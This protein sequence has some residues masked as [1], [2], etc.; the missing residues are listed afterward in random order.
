MLE[1]GFSTEEFEAAKAE[2]AGTIEEAVRF[3]QS[4]PYP[5]LD[6]ITDYVYSEPSVT[7]GGIKQ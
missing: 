5:S 6:T 2:A 4:S 3:A 7:E 1:N